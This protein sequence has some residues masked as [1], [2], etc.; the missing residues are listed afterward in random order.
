MLVLK[1]STVDA[2][3][4]SAGS[5]FHSL[6]VDGKNDCWWNWSLECGS[7]YL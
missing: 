4:A 5:S 1:A 6:M 3:A 2:E 7:W